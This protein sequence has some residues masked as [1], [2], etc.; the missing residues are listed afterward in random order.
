MKTAWFVFSGVCFFLFIVSFPVFQLFQ[1]VAI[2]KFSYSMLGLS[3]LPLLALQVKGVRGR[4]AG[5]W[6]VT[7]AAIDIIVAAVLLFLSGLST[8]ESQIDPTLFIGMTLALAAALF[9]SLKRLGIALR[10]RRIR[11]EKK[12]MALA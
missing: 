4:L 9:F 6:L 8:L 1:S 10:K 5:V 7:S 2:M 11:K 12:E 3:L